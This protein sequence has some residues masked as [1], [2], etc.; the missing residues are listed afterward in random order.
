MKK[1]LSP[2]MS[3]LAALLLIFAGM[4]VYSRPESAATEPTAVKNIVID[5]LTLDKCGGKSCYILRDTAGTE[6]VFSRLPESLRSRSLSGETAEIRYSLRGGVK[7]LRQLSINGER[8]LYERQNGGPALAHIAG[9]VII[10]L[11]FLL[12]WLFVS[13]LTRAKKTE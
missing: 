4:Y 7:T 13:L 5:S 11:G 1:Y 9:G 12:L 3:L 8:L 10:S 6:Y 2:A